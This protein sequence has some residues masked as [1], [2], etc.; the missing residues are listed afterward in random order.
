MR[1][2][3]VGEVGVIGEVEVGESRGGG[4]LGEVIENEGE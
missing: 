4:R 1:V 3:E 2:E